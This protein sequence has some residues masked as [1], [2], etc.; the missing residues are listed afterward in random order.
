MLK[1]LLVD[2][3]PFIM[4]G[5]QV[6]IDWEQ[7]GYEQPRTAS[8]GQEAL[9]VLKDFPADLIIADINMPVKTG[10][11]MLKELRIEQNKDT[12]VVILSG[13][14]EFSYVQEAM[15]YACTDYILKPVEKENLTSVLRKVSAMKEISDK[16]KREGEL[17]EK[18][19][20]DRNLIALFLG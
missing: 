18:A 3:E 16:E 8:N 15:R 11:E 4:Q 17:R 2:D 9:E 19:Y 5:L 12:Y 10:L 6:L 14:A 7:E 20:L 13:Y 1:V